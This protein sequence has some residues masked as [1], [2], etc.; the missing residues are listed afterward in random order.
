MLRPGAGFVQHC[1]PAARG[2]LSFL[3]LIRA[4]SPPVHQHEGGPRRCGGRMSNGENKNKSETATWTSS[5]LNNLLT[6]CGY[7]TA[8]QNSSPSRGTNRPNGG[9]FHATAVANLI[10]AGAGSGERRDETGE[11]A[12]SIHPRPLSTI[13]QS[14]PPPTTEPAATVFVRPSVGRRVLRHDRNTHKFTRASADRRPP[15]VP[16]TTCDFYPN[17]PNNP[18]KVEIIRPKTAESRG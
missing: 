12:L 13:A 15:A 17:N 7:W 8:R 11:I 1:Q 3:S 5:M 4:F 10:C 6:V 16:E 9:L 14:A 2:L 18:S